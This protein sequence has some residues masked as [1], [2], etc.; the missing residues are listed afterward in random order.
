ML[1]ATLHEPS[2]LE[3]TTRVLLSNKKKISKSKVKATIQ[4]IMRVNIPKKNSY[5]VA[6]ALWLAKSLEIKIDHKLIQQIFSSGDAIPILIALDLRNSK[7]VQGHTS[8]N[9]LNG[10]LTEDSL[11]DERWL[12]SYEAIV[13]KWLKPHIPNLLN[14]NPYF[15]IL[16]QNKISFYD[17]EKQVATY[18]LK[19]KV[20]KSIREEKDT[21][22]K[23]EEYSKENPFEIN[24]FD[25]VFYRPGA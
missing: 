1:K 13:K 25:Q 8:I 20:A 24:V 9:V 19:R 15:K 6:W 3:E 17:D 12:L 7:L 10:E 14:K 22:P 18:S 5:E 4:E 16:L 21:V 2:I 23:E 11:F